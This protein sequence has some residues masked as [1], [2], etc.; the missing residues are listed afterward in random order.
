MVARSAPGVLSSRGM[1][2]SP[3]REEGQVEEGGCEM[4][5]EMELLLFWGK[6]NLKGL[7][8]EKG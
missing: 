4:N 5:A 1:V 8:Q 6:R 2:D 3:S 7:F